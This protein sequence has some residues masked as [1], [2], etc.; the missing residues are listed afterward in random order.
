MSPE[1]L[2][3]DGYDFKSDI[4]SLGCLLYEL[5]MLK[6]PFKA[7]G[8][9]LYS[10]FQK[11]SQGDYQPLPKN[12]SENLRNLAYLM[13]STRSED[14]PEISDACIT[15]SALRIQSASVKKNSIDMPISNNIVIDVI[16]NN[17]ENNKN[18]D[19]KN[20]NNNNNNKNDNGIVGIDRKKGNIL[21]QNNVDKE[22]KN[23]ST[24]E[25][26]SNIDSMSIKDETNIIE[27]KNNG[28][29]SKIGD[30]ADR[31]SNQKETDIKNNQIDL[32]EMKNNI[33]IDKSKNENIK[34]EATE[35]IKI[36]NNDDKKLG[37]I[38]KVNLTR[39]IV[40]ESNT[41]SD[42]KDDSKII[43]KSPQKKIISTAYLDNKFHD[44]L[45]NVDNNNNNNNNNKNNNN[46]N[47]NKKGSNNKKSNDINNNSSNSND[48]NK[49]DLIPVGN[50]KSITRDKKEN[51]NENENGRENVIEK[52]KL[53]DTKLKKDMIIKTNSNSSDSDYNTYTNGISVSN[54]STNVSNNNYHNNKEYVNGYDKINRSN[55]ITRSKGFDNADSYGMVRYYVI[56]QSTI[57]DIIFNYVIPYNIL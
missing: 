57:C 20:D 16:N 4:W 32:K 52:R 45:K 11:I 13:I 41:K 51:E 12:Y 47:N 56:N 7:E 54:I 36:Q 19:N 6:S 31:K 39:A 44:N 1:V 40:D 50:S 35:E 49:T 23:K 9:N 24:K 25:D 30:K 26:D 42:C 21:N 37:Y 15:A 28:K 14:R 55:G 34:K 10:L 22:I 53:S 48:K 2:R 27:E 38:D 5:T 33:L 43:E 3:G 8:L 18:N 29:D 17:N 46:D